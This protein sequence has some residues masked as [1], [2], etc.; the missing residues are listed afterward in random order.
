MSFSGLPTLRW[1]II[2]TGL[3]SSWFVEDLVLERNDAK[4]RH[5]IQAI[6]SSSREKG[7]GFVKKYIP[8]VSPTVYDNY[9][10][11]YND[12]N[13]DI[14]Y[15][16]TPHAFHKKNCL[17][18]IAAGKHILCEKAFT[19]TAKEAKQV[20]AVAEA[21]GVFIMEAIWTRFNPLVLS[22]Q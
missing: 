18:A 3:I 12:P 4:A 9:S 2:A 20:L 11:V 15:I 21:N 14:V 5:V 13:V 10:D 17:D 6:G 22:L 16:G 7:E 8:S 1:G 19:I